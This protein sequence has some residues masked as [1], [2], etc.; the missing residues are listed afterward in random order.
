MTHCA[1]DLVA[2]W[3]V[4][5]ILNT[6]DAA[7]LLA[8]SPPRGEACV[9]IRRYCDDAAVFANGWICG[10][11]LLLYRFFRDVSA[12]RFHRVHLFQV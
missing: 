3:T 4:N 9:H 7:C 1:C 8:L 11:I 2:K 6:A 5:A 10:R 12:G